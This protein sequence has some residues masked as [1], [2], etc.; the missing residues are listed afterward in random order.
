MDDKKTKLIVKRIRIILLVL[1]ALWLLMIFGFS[2]QDGDAS[3]S[4]SLKVAQFFFKNEEV[5]QSMVGP[6]R[7]MAHVLEY[8]VGGFLTSIF[9]LTYPV[10][11]WKRFFYVS[12]FIAIVAILDEV[13]QHFIPGRNGVWYDVLIDIG[14]CIL[15]VV[16]TNIFIRLISVVDY[17]ATDSGNNEEDGTDNPYKY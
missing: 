10:D 16:I 6:I 15:G 2:Q 17:F 9:V 5:A 4:L 1:I 14:G 11:Y 3:G 8:S 7:K 13:H 12:G